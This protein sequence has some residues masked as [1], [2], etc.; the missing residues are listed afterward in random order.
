VLG[1][2]NPERYGFLVQYGDEIFTLFNLAI[3]HHYLKNYGSSFSESFYDLK[4]V[5]LRSSKTLESLRLPRRIYLQSL[6]AL[7]ALP[8]I[9]NWIDSAYQKTRE[10]EA[11]GQ[12]PSEGFRNRFLRI[13]LKLWPIIHFSWEF[14]NFVYYI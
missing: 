6:S 9:R 13:F 2:S 4:R 11:D 5:P 1:E 12:L 10:R 3:Q 8:Y 14:V 7:V